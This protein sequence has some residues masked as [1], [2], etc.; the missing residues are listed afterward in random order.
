MCIK[1]DSHFILYAHKTDRMKTRLVKTNLKKNQ[2]GG[3][4]LLKFDGG[5]SLI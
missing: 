5:L 2:K 3:L 1:S 4:D